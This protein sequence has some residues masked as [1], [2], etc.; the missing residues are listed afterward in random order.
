MGLSLC[1]SSSI[2][3]RPLPSRDTGGPPATIKFRNTAEAWF[4]TMAA[5][6]ARRDGDAK[7]GIRIVR[8]CDPDDII[9]CLDQLYRGRR[10]DRSH[11]QVLRVWG[12]RQ[13]AP[14]S[15][16]EG[17]LCDHRL[18]I[19]AMTCLQPLLQAKGIID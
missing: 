12:E 11:A 9:R 4:W 13:T 2:A 1:H 6:A 8:P 18:W 19:E 5:L 16:F 15:R 10:I 7:S 3:R 17:E 14:A